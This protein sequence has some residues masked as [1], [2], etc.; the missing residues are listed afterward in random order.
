[1]PDWVA[2][3]PWPLQPAHSTGKM[4]R[5]AE[6]PARRAKEL[7]AIDR[8]LYPERFGRP[9]TRA[10]CVDLPRP[11]PF[12]GCKHNLYMNVKP[13]TGTIRWNYDCEPLEMETSCALDVAARGG[14]SLEDTGKIIGITRERVRQIEEVALAKLAALDKDFELPVARSASVWERMGGV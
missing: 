13:D 2:P 14:M 5:K 7:R 9:R 6:H 1:M 3:L 8:L 4:R 11:C 12:V 10:E